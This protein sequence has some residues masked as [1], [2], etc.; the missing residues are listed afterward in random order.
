[1]V[2]KRQATYLDSTGLVIGS[3]SICVSRTGIAPALPLLVG[4]LGILVLG[5]YLAYVGRRIPTEFNESKWTAMTPVMIMEAFLIGIPV[6][7]LANNQPIPGYII[8]FMVA[9]MVATVGLIF[10]PKVAIADGWGEE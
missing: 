9:P 7:V 8:K 10:G 1:M 4:I 2:W 5:N 6:L 3:M